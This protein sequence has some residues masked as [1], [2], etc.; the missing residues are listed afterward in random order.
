MLYFSAPVCYVVLSKFRIRIASIFKCYK[1]GISPSQNVNSNQSSSQIEKKYWQVQLKDEQ[2]WNVQYYAVQF[3]FSRMHFL[4]SLEYMFCIGRPNLF[5]ICTCS[6]F[7][8]H[9]SQCIIYIF[10]ID[11]PNLFGK[12][13]C[14]TFCIHWS[15]YFAH[16]AL[17]P[18][19]CISSV[20]QIWFCIFCQFCIDIFPLTCTT[21]SI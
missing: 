11:R 19:G 13:T 2:F 8:I 17:L 1:L 5:G 3:T 10:R 20:L 18:S 14:S 12:C 7:C 9:W 16:I 15:Q 21:L 4:H 6:I